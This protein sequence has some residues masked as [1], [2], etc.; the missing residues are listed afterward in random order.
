MRIAIGHRTY[1]V[2]RF[3]SRCP[4]LARDFLVL[5]DRLHRQS[6][7]A[8]SAMIGV[9]IACF[10]MYA[11]AEKHHLTSSFFYG[12]L[13]F[14]FIDGG[15]PETFGY[16]LELAACTLFV[17]S[18]WVRRKKQWY[19]W[20]AILLV[21]FLDDAFELH[22]TIGGFFA[23]G[24]GLSPVAGDLAGF[25]STGLLSA[26]FWLAGARLLHS[27]EDWLPYLVFTAYFA[28]LIFFGVGVDAV[29]GMLG[30]NVSQTL[31]TLIED[32]GELVVTALIS[33]SAF[34]MWL[35]H[36]RTV[37]ASETPLDSVLPNP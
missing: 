5:S 6:V 21:T 24:F 12:R 10:L 30:R 9:L 13:R 7:A 19:A 26:V 2:T 32:G 11:Y 31:L 29:H 36:K 20:A 18:A 16:G 37:I 33:L 35:R 23:A 3:M 34:G 22:E 4:R 17:M 25:A 28:V 1:S 27:E 15:Y 8:V 14:S